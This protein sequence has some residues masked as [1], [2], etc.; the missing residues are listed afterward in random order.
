MDPN[1]NRID[2]V[3]YF[4]VPF[5]DFFTLQDNAGNPYPL[6]SKLAVANIRYGTPESPGLIALAVNEGTGMISRNT[7]TGVVT[8]A[9]TAAAMSSLAVGDYW[10]ELLITDG[11]GNVVDRPAF[12]FWTH[13]PT[14]VGMS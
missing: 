12:G 6:T 1:A 2:C 13:T 5:S 3:S 9:L 7:S 10:Y 14:G 4:G 8:R 11:S